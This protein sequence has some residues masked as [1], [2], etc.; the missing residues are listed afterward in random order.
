M[1]AGL[2]VIVLV[3]A[4]QDG[5]SALVLGVQQ[6]DLQQYDLGNRVGVGALRC[7]FLKRLLQVHSTGFDCMAFVFLGSRYAV[8]VLI[9]GVVVKAGKGYRL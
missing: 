3:L 4:G 8:D 9:D 7:W 2:V 1:L 5:V 6:H